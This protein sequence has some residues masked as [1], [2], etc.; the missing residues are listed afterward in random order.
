MQ[1]DTLHKVLAKVFKTESKKHPEHNELYLKVAK[2]FDNYNWRHAYEFIS[3]NNDIFYNDL[4]TIRRAIC[5]WFLEEGFDSLNDDYDSYSDSCYT[6]LSDLANGAYDLIKISDRG[7]G[8]EAGKVNVNQHNLFYWYDLDDSE[9]AEYK[10]ALHRNHCAK[11]C[12]AFGPIADL[13]KYYWVSKR[14]IYIRQRISAYE[15]NVSHSQSEV[16]A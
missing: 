16:T 1:H 2:A 10:W 7:F 14:I 12:M 15:N 5:D 13:A 9:E 11:K 6:L 3:K 4:Y 8:V